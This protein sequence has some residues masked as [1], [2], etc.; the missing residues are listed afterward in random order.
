LDI[1]KQQ[2]INRDKEVDQLKLQLKNLKRSRSS[3]VSANTRKQFSVNT[4]TS[5]TDSASTDMNSSSS[6][7]SSAESS[8]TNTSN[9]NEEMSSETRKPRSMSFDAS[10]TLSK[11]V[12]I[13]N[14]EIK[15]LRNKISRL[16]DDLLFVTQVCKFYLIYLF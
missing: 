12:E 1:L 4:N 2:L 11:Q 6:S 7:S 14:D 10:E 8:S 13:A 15:L 3:E 16:E 5:K 9:N